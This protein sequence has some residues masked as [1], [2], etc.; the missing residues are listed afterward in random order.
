M[1]GAILAGV[2]VAAAVLL[3]VAPAP[4]QTQ[5]PQQLPQQLPQATTP[6]VP[7]QGMPSMAAPTIPPINLVPAF[8]QKG[9]VYTFTIVRK[10]LK[11]EVMDVDRTGWIRV[12][13]LEDDEE[14]DGIPW[15]NLNHV[16]LILPEKPA[17]KPEKD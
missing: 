16:T 17:V 14:Y 15:L 9:K 6:K 8:I 2:T 10:E 1:R 7:A 11:G 12:N 5:Q 4:A 3:A 13:F